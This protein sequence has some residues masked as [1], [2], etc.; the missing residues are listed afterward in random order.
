[1]TVARPFLYG[2]LGTSLVAKQVVHWLLKDI[3]KEEVL[4]VTERWTVRCC[5]FL[6]SFAA[7]R[8]VCCRHPT[9]EHRSY[10]PSKQEDL[11]Y[12]QFLEEPPFE[13]HYHPVP[14]RI[15]QSHST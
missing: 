2:A 11:Y 13:E 5:L 12:S 9:Y 10:Y 4:L 7:L 8:R 15:R 6:F 14:S 3:L 1:M